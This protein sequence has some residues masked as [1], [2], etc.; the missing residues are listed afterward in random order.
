MKNIRIVIDG[1]AGAG[2]STISK[3]AAKELGFVYIDTG[4]MY[5]AVGL[6]ALRAG[7]DTK[8]NHAAVIS[9]MDG[10]A[11]DIKH[12]GDGQ[13][14]YLDGE[15]VTAELRTP[16]VSIAA[17]DVSAIPEVRLKLVALQRRLAE[18]DNIVMD[19]RDIGSYV[20]PD[21]EVKIFLTASVED[22]A[23]RRHDELS[24]KGIQV[25]LDEVRSDMEYRDK[26]DSARDFAPLK[27]ADGAMVIDTTG[28]S[29]EQSVD[30]LI[31]TIKE[32]LRCFSR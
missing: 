10:V 27:I 5:R 8:N 19:G 13:L 6:K 4:A 1:P 12:G 31:G 21:A 26:N 28:N 18:K 25:S 24:E 14:V 17:S 16:E 11:I 7:I 29:L 9:L 3:I 2:K 20:L 23:K 30:L 22:R 32:R 15:D